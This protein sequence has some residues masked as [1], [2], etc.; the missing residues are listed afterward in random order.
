MPSKQL[1]LIGLR[2]LILLGWLFGAILPFTSLAQTS[3]ASSAPLTIKEFN[4]RREA[5]ANF[6]YQEFKAAWFGFLKGTTPAAPTTADPAWAR[7]A[8]EE[9]LLTTGN[10]K[11][12]LARA[13]QNNNY[14]FT[15]QQPEDDMVRIASFHRGQKSIYMNADRM[16]ANEWLITFVHEVAHSLDSELV[17]SLDIFND[18]NLTRE[19][20]DLGRQGML[21]K[22]LSAD[23]R[24]RLDRW[25]LAGLNRGF[26]TE[27]RAWFLTFMVYEEGLKDGTFSKVEWLEKLKSTRPERTSIQTHIFR[28]LSSSWTDPSEGLFTYPFIQQALSEIREKLYQNP[29]R[30]SLG[31]IGKLI[32]RAR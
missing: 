25:L 28:F 3:G 11:S 15:L 19:L 6:H 26:L 16:S 1:P 32:Q 31:E 21:L 2:K 7:R 14:G 18:K 9:Y 13:S 30:V 23:D 20:A 12:R 8:T 10:L 17:A 27:Y 4:D 24:V 22:D 29:E 5:A